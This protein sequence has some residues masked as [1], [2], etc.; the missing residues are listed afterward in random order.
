MIRYK[1]ESATYAPAVPDKYER[2]SRILHQSL[3]SQEDTEMICKASSR[4]CMFF[5]EISTMSDNSRDRNGLTAPKT[6]LERPGPNLHPVLIARHMLHLATFLQHL[7]PDIHEE[8][9]GLSEPPRVMMKRLADTAISLVTTNEEL[10]GNIEGLE[11]ITM[12]CKYHANGGNLRR[13]L[14][15]VRRAIV[16]AQLMGLHCV[17][18][19]AQYKVLDPK[20]KVDTQYIWFQNLF[21]DRHLCLLLGLP[22]FCADESMASDEMLA[23]ETP[24]GRLERL[25]CVLASRIL[26]R[27]ESNPSSHDFALTKDLDLEL[28]KT[29]KIMPSKWW[30]IPNLASVVHDPQALFSDT[31]RLVH[32]MLHYSLLN[33]LHLPHMLRPSA[34]HKYSKIMCVNASRELL[35]RFIMF[36]SLNHIASCFHI[37]DFL[38]LMAGLTLLLAHLDSHCSSQT[39]NLLAHQCH[40]QQ[41]LSD[42]AM[43]EQA[44]ENMEEV[45]RLNTDAL[46][47]QSAD[48]LRRLLA[49]EI[50]VADGHTHVAESVSVLQAPET[51]M[52]PDEDNNSVVRVYIPY[53]GTIKIAREGGISKE[54]PKAQTSGPGPS[55]QNQP[56]ILGSPQTRHTNA[57]VRSFNF[58]GLGVN[59]NAGTMSPAEAVGCDCVDELPAMLQRV[60]CPYAET[61]VP[62]TGD[63]V[64]TAQFTPQFGNAVSDPLLQQYQYPELTAGVE[65][66]AFQGVDMAFFDSLMRG[67][68]GS[69]N[70][71]AEWVTWQNTE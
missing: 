50:E 11:C 47:A 21:C 23:N 39:D 49:I 2:L 54:M 61:H 30:L 34:E 37:I 18:R 15:A 70:G 14:M 1:V 52:Q 16:V 62:F 3:P 68:E 7:H 19:S 27:N 63:S 9:K 60:S 8:I 42:R 65:D 29:A 45:S 66:W 35:S 69:V 26:A 28:Q 67:A 38:A 24:L 57:T 58:D 4:V 10:I 17:H 64:V 40:P 36:R 46:S 43:I 48:L 53:F 33:K 5:Q 44:L 55:S 22:Q 59:P 71:A 56:P 20:T 25:H 51:E 31:R 32:Q 6:L 41:C 12:E 13:A